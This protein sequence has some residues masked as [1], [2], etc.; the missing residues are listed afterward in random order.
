MNRPIATMTEAMQVELLM[1]QAK[2][3]GRH[4]TCSQAYDDVRRENRNTK[5]SQPTLKETP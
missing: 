4:L 5:A 2:A 1:R 3:E